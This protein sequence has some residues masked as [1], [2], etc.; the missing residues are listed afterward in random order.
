LN[1]NLQVNR[2]LQ[3]E[4]AI[5]R[6]LENALLELDVMNLRDEISHLMETETSWNVSEQ[7]IE[8]FISGSLE[9]EELELFRAELSENTDLKAEVALRRNIDKSPLERKIYLTSVINCIM[10]STR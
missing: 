10:F 8:D 6:E 7:Q 1:R 3:R 9:G 2:I 4:V 5:H